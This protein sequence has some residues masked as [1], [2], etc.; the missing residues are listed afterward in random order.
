MILSS[1]E[2]PPAG[3]ECY[4]D[5][6]ELTHRLVAAGM[7]AEA[8][9]TR[10]VLF[11]RCDTALCSDMGHG[12]SAVRGRTLGLFVPGRIEV[13]GKHTDYAGGRSLLCAI[14]RGMC[15][16][17]RPR[18]DRQ[19]R[20]LALN[21]GEMVEFELSPDL[22]PLPGHWSNY[23]MTVARRVARNFAGALCGA[24]IVMLSDLPSAA[25][26]SSSSAMIVGTFMLLSRI[27]ELQ[28]RPAY[29]VAVGSETELAS[30]LGTVENGRGFGTLGGDRGVG[31]FG[32][33][34]DHTAILLCRAGQLS[35]YSFCPARAE[36]TVAVPA[37][38]CFVVAN[39]GVVAEK[40]GGAMEAFNAISRRA[41]LL[42]EIWNVHTG[43]RDACLADVVRSS[44]G[45]FRA[46]AGTGQRRIT[47][48]DRSAAC[49]PA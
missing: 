40:S 4:D 21:Q 20:F 49:S 17:A 5:E 8:A 38:Y 26:L 36:G 25:G 34:E 47:R 45:A 33:S 29:R 22:K 43:R 30:Y 23:P 18:P 48:R 12:P 28:N 15:M 42:L 6:A 44:S 13:L 41:T 14:E 46:T 11:K 19:I 3:C 32:G 9:R 37:G 7:S 39:S 16:L 2:A 10:A 27:N 1:L 24:D 31:T 35:L